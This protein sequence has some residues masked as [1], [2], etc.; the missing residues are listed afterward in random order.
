MTSRDPERSSE[1]RKKIASAFS[2]DPLSCGMMP[3]IPVSQTEYLAA[4][5]LREWIGPAQEVLS[6]VFDPTVTGDGRFRLG[7][8]PSMNRTAALEV[9]DAAVEAFDRGRG[10]WPTMPVR[11]RITRVEDFAMAMRE[12]REE[13][14]RLIMWEIGKTR[15]DSEKEFDRTIVYIRDTVDALKDLDRI[16]SGFTIEDGIVGQIRR[17]PLG[18]CLCM[19]PFNYPLN[20]TFTTLIPAL[21]MGNTVVFKPPKFGVLLHRPL[22]EAFRDCFP[23][24]VVNTVYGDGR[25]VA[26]PLM[27][28]GKIDILAFIGTS[29][30]ADILRKAHPKPHRL[31]CVLGLE[32]KNCAIVLADADL[33]GAVKECLTGALSFNGQRCTALKMIFVHSSICHSFLEAM[34]EGIG[35]LNP[36]WPWTAGVNLTPLPEDGKAA[37]MTELV[38]QAVALGAQ[39][40]NP[41]GGEVMGSYFHPAMV[42]PVK[43]G[44]KLYDEEQF[45]PV[46][47]IASFDD[48]TEPLDYVV[49]SN[50]GQQVS[51]FSRE[52]AT[53]GRLLDQLVNQVC[54]V[55]INSQCQRGPDSFPFTGRKDSAEGTLSVSDALRA[56]SIRSL[57]AARKNEVNEEIMT[58]IVRGGLSG[59]LSR[60]FIL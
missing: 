35:K 33:E 9:L 17:A 22:L 42:F 18:V 2:S 28:T 55:N 24:G 31:R 19:G 57:V 7:S 21:I 51:L 8:Y 54:R 34:K 46:I 43:P 10:V 13:V 48:V 3:E 20:E 23:P 39:V 44:A 47:P 56:F 40:V 1:V 32:A 36:G 58:A 37:Q 41:G 16:S 25:E 29:R 15:A 4:G 14:V 6:P 38:S 53:T 26:G 59:F 60:D 50:Y 30:V 5:R 52:P 45:G 27:E 11:D 49:N 12:K